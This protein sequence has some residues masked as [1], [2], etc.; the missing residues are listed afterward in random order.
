LKLRFLGGTMEVGRSSVSLK[1]AGKQILLDS[2]V[3]VDH[4]PGFP[5][6][7]PPR[8]VDAIF[9]THAHLDHSG[10]T[11]IFHI[12]S[13]IP[14]HATGLTFE[15]A[16]LLI[17][18]FIK[19]SGYFLP[20]E[21]VD[22]ENMMQASNELEYGGVVE[23]G[24]IRITM[25]RAGHI[26]GSS[27]F[28]VES[29]GKKILY[30]GDINTE[31]TK[32]LDG[33]ETP[34]EGLDAIIMESTY[35][36]ED[37]PNRAETE[38]RFVEKAR[39][40][41]ER[42]GVALVPAFAVGRSQEILGVFTAYHFEHTVSIDGMALET[43]EILMRNMR[44]LRDQRLFMEAVR[45]AQWMNG[46]KDRRTAVRNPGVIVSPAGMLKGGAAVFYTERVAKDPNNAILIVSYQV[47]GTPGRQLIDKKMFSIGG[48]MRRVE[49]EVAQFDF[50]SHVGRK[51][52]HDLVH[53]FD[54]KTKVYLM[55][56]AEGACQSFAS[57][58]RSDTG[59]E[60]VVPEA[61]ET[62]E[63]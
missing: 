61:G 48:K 16:K 29:E 60:T 1:A 10:L 7:V 15:L 59:L 9:L 57:W 56:G 27:Q 26:P 43:N 58:I 51:E 35:A 50:S 14:V 11:P 34:Y 17:A 31:E 25:F 38:K 20:F 13:R 36:N 49:A 8:E 45:S 33:A 3:M 4:A 41:V 6:H 44:Y 63:V 37:H 5:I 46:W 47:P 55:H 23:L 24:G 54:S 62:Y 42:E 21:Y 28:L 39:E 12:R 53:K 52:L 30:T 19:L 32:L 18:D 22:L 2:G 40:V